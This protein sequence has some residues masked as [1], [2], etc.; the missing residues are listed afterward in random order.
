MNEK[1]RK[2]TEIQIGFRDLKK[3]KKTYFWKYF[4]KMLPMYSIISYNFS[5]FIFYNIY[6]LLFLQK[7]EI[8]QSWIFL[9]H[10]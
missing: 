1:C 5:P 4:L 3:K 7:M 10:C 6:I 9:L 2:C 8:L